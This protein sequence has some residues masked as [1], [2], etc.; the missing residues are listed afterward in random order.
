[1]VF[2]IRARR[3]WTSYPNTDLARLGHNRRYY[4]VCVLVCGME[5]PDRLRLRRDSDTVV[6]WPMVIRSSHGHYASAI[7]LQINAPSFALIRS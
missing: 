4:I 3:A 5:L 6:Q 1:M 7:G 2:H